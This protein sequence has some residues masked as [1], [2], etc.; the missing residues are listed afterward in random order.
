V[1]ILDF[2][3]DSDSTETFGGKPVKLFIRGDSGGNNDDL[4]I[5]FDNTAPF[6]A[7]TWHLVGSFVPS[8]AAYGGAT[9]NVYA[10]DTGNNQIAVEQGV[11]V[12]N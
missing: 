11:S 5:P 6:T 1:D 2:Q 8:D 4:H 10:D 9:Y 12:Q 3:S 7:G